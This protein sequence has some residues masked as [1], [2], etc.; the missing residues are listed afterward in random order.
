MVGSV[1]YGADEGEG[2]S[3]GFPAICYQILSTH[4]RNLPYLLERY[5][6][7]ERIRTADLYRVN[8]LT[9]GFSTTYNTVG[10]A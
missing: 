6:R 8:R 10:T 7:H 2:K 9:I 4:R 5:G 3:S 1:L